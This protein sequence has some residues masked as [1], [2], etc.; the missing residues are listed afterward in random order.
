MVVDLWETQDLPAERLSL[1][2]TDGMGRHGGG[3]MG[4]ST[5]SRTKRPRPKKH[6]PPI[7]S[8][9]PGRRGTA[10]RTKRPR[11]KKHPPPISSPNP[12]R[13]GTASRTKRRSITTSTPVEVGQPPRPTP[14][15]GEPPGRSITTSTPVEVGQP[16][17]PTPNRG[18]PP[19]RSITTSR[20]T[21]M[22]TRFHLARRRSRHRGP[23]FVRGRKTSM[24]TRFHLARR[25][26]RHRGPAF[27]RGRKTSMPT[28][29]S[30]RA[31]TAG[32][33]YL[34]RQPFVR[35]ASCLPCQVERPRPVD[36]TCAGSLSSGTLPACRVRSSD[37]GSDDTAQPRPP[38][39]KSVIEFPSPLG[40]L[41]L[42]TL[43]NRGHRSKKV[44]LSFRPLSGFWV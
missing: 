39:K 34:C 44:L 31:T 3:P 40:V 21:S 43:L 27:V 42:T 26:S 12:G 17:R 20:K 10:S 28:P 25:R 35:H 29:V 41:G 14:N 18:E 7:S 19:G 1:T 13:R 22:P 8:P 36:R 16:P 33:P 2:P 30:G 9:N 24:P 15:R 37:H 6:P 5:A 38:L 4:D 11:P 23:A 32:R